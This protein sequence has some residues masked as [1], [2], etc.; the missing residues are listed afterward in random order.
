MMNGNGLQIRRL[1]E[2]DKSLLVKWLNDPRV[3]QYYEGRDNPHDLQKVE[4]HF[5][6][7]DDSGV[8]CLVTY[9]EI[10]IGYI[11]FYELGEEAKQEYGYSRKLR[12]YGTDQFLGEPGY[13]GRGIGTQLVQL[14]TGYLMREKGADAVVMDPQ[15]WNERA[16][17]CYEKCGFRRVRLLPRHEWHEGELR[18]CWLMEYAG[19]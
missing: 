1:I 18:D 9:E 7:P 17:A 14:M 10:S 6:R 16:L 3:L 15:A 12:I 2:D 11:Q 8:R 5:Y 4:A 19:K 13:W